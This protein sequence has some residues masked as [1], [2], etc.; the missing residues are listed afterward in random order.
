MLPVAAFAVGALMVA[1]S[2]LPRFGPFRTGLVVTTFGLALVLGRDHGGY[3]GRG[4]DAAFGG[5]IGTTGARLLGGFLVLAG[6][7]ARQ[8]RLCR[9]AP[10]AIRPRRSR[11]GAQATGPSRR[12]RVPASTLPE[13]SPAAPVAASAPPVDGVQEFPDVV[14][15][16]PLLDGVRGSRELAVDDAALAL[17]R[18]RRRR[19]RRRLHASRPWRPATVEAGGPRRGR[20][21]RTDRGGARAGARELR[22][23]RDRQSARSPARA[24]PGTS[25]SSRPERRSR[26]S[27]R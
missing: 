15:P 4:L 3:L 12:R 1:K 27:R 17:R 24:S 23:R 14:A 18:D 6:V 26:R 5:L 7:P 11:R 8:R 2:D 9:R 22:R 16:S 20:V 19:G 10:A 21:E 13:P 25:S